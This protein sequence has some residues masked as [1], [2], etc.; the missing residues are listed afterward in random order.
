[1]H[2]Y[3]RRLSAALAELGV[4]YRPA[5]RPSRVELSHFHLANST[6][7]VIPQAGLERRGFLLTVHDVI[8]RTSLLEPLHR[9]LLLPLCVNRARRVIVHSRH[10]ANLL[11]REVGI[12]AVRVEIIPH[13]ARD[14]RGMDRSAAR[15]AIG[16]DP[17]GPPV[18]VLPGT[19]KPAKLVRETLSAAAPLLAAGRLRMVLAGRVSD[20]RLLSGATALGVLVLRDPPA[21]QY[22][23]AIVAA[24][25]VVCVRASSVGES[26]GPLLD[27]IGAGRPSLV[28]AVG[29]APEVARESARIVE[30]TMAEI[31]AGLE[32]LLNDD[33]RGRRA[34]AASARADQLTWEQAAR[35]HLDLLEELG[36]G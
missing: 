29:S 15:A 8:P 1:V 19:L 16:L 25:L 36:D 28:T 17:E 5:T 32:A 14:L 35:R 10:A 3:V 6:R 30:P 34:A 9:A 24:D 23:H 21:E 13:P 18:A 4:S 22:D 20:E 33:E 11:Q 12:P 26:N 2:V 7:R 31:R 27:A